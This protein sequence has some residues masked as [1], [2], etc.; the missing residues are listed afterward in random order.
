MRMDQRRLT[1][2]DL[3]DGEARCY[4]LHPEERGHRLTVVS[5]NETLHIYLPEQDLGQL[6]DLFHSESAPR[7]AQQPQQALPAGATMEWLA[8]N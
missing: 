3:N 5:K 8:Y 6:R 1:I 2:L 4:L 7:P